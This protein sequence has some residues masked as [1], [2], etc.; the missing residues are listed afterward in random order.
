M[1]LDIPKNDNPTKLNNIENIPFLETRKYVKL[2][3][4]NIFFYKLLIGDEEVQDPIHFN[5]IYDIKVGFNR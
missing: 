2:I 3:F 4:R 5:Q 1:Y